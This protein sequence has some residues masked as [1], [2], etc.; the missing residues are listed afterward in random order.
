MM[1]AI[2]EKAPK[3]RLKNQ[4]GETVALSDFKGRK[5]ILYFYPK[6]DTPG[7]T[8]EAIGFSEALKV[9]KKQNGVV[10]GIS[11]DSSASHRQFADKHQL[12]I[13]LLADEDGKIC[14]AY[15]VWQKKTNFGKIY[16]GILRSTFLIDEE[17]L[18]EQ[19]W[20]SVKV[21]GHVERVCS[22]L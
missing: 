19:R 7:C 14:E 3:F 8:K 21:D 16:L 11:K 2:G 10:L 17:G 1:P 5:V 13:D 22:F 12:S 6:D 20:K 4:D 15:G 18:I 9:I